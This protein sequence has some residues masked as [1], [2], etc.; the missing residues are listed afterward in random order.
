VGLLQKEFISSSTFFRRTSLQVMSIYNG[1]FKSLNIVVIV[2]VY[3][4]SCFPNYYNPMLCIV[5][6]FQQLGASVIMVAS[7][8]NSNHWRQLCMGQSIGKDGGMVRAIK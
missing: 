8:V 1:L 6:Q 4:V 3:K 2:V 7:L 5:L